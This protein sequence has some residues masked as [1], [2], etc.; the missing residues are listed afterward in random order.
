MK[1]RVAVLHPHVVPAT[2]HCSICCHE[3]GADLH[4]TRDSSSTL[5][6]S[7]YGMGL[8]VCVCV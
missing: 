4:E 8:F 3:S 7:V 1:D 6:P 2:E 5:F